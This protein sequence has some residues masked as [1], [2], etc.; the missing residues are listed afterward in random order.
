MGV[1][2]DAGETGFTAVVIGYSVG[3]DGGVE[4]GADDFGGIGGR[5]HGDTWHGDRFER[6]T[7]DFGLDSRKENDTGDED[8]QNEED[9][10]ENPERLLA[11]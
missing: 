5:C 3:T 2:G 1:G 10:E 8:S 9:G 11:T 7:T 6:T 4:L